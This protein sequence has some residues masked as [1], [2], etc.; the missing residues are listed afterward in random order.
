MK[1]GKYQL[2]LIYGSI[3]W[4]NDAAYENPGAPP[5]GSVRPPA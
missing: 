3:Y 4:P 5:N 2:D 1:E